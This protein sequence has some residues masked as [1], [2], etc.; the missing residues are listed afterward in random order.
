MIKKIFL[1]IAIFTILLLILFS[2]TN[3]KKS[4]VVKQ[5]NKNKVALKIVPNKYTDRY[6]NMKIVDINYSAQAIMPNND[7]FFFDDPGCMVS[8]FKNQKNKS[9]IV[10]WV[11]A[12]DIKKYINARDA[13]YSSNETTPMEYGFGAYKIRIYGYINFQTMKLK[14]FRGETLQNDIIRKKEL[15]NFNG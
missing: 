4:V 8:W 10:L 13:W 3:F 9:D 5:H 12:K 11:W 1:F 14:V 7:T 6:C 15:K 2:T